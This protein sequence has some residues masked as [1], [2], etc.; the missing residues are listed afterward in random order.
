M[1]T[2][3]LSKNNLISFK[4]C[5]KVGDKL[6]NFGLEEKEVF[7]RSWMVEEDKFIEDDAEEVEVFANVAAGWEL[8]GNS[9]QDLFLQY[10]Q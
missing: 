3:H 4:F 10:V 1:Q 7:V 2:Q 8:D 9:T 6:H 5:D